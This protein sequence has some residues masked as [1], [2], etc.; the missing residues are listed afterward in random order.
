MNE[1]IST[2]ESFLGLANAY[3]KAAEL[4]AA[5]ISTERIPDFIASACMFN[6]RLSIEQFLKGMIVLRDPAA[7]FVSHK[8]EE[9]SIE[10]HKCF[11]EPE[12]VWSIPFTTQV[13]G[14]NDSERALAIRENLKA[15]PLDQ[16]FR[17]PIDNKGKPWAMVEN[18]QTSWFS[19][20]THDIRKSMN[21]IRSAAEAFPDG[22]A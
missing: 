1:I 11:P 8:L 22:K 10:F 15:R 21:R 19:A 7:K 13:I 20:F 12:Y 6:A 5:D 3:L 14:G 18:V 2:T 16:V 4:L 9:L 17:Y